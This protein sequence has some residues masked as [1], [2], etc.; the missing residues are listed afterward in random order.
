LVVNGLAPGTDEAALYLRLA[1]VVSLRALRLVEQVRPPR[2]LHMVAAA[3]R[4]SSHAPPVH[5][6][7]RA[8]SLTLSHSTLSHSLSDS[9]SHSPLSHFTQL[10]LTLSL[11]L[12]LSLNSL[13]LSLRLSLSL[14][15]SLSLNSLSPRLA[16][17][18]SSHSHS[19]STL[20]HSL[21]LSQPAE[22]GSAVPAFALLDLHSVDDA[23]RIK[24]LL[25][26]AP[27]VGGSSLT[28]EFTCAP[29][30][31]PPPHATHTALQLHRGSPLQVHTCSSLQVRAR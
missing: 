20:S 17:A 15:L 4:C 14:S 26:G 23:T 2:G 16:L 5:R 13:S 25:D 27:E 19:H 12:S 10:S 24:A 3:A 21:S 11:S 6:G 18:L 30:P 29:L 28:V 7:G 9:H 1:P 8:S 31:P 22:V